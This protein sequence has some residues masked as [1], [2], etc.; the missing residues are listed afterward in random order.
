MALGEQPEAPRARARRRS[1]VGAEL[2]PKRA[3]YD[4]AQLD[5]RTG[6]LTPSWMRASVP[7]EQE[8]LDPVSTPNHELNDADV[9]ARGLALEPPV[10]L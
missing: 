6:A 1:G 3:S 2:W 5:T 7:S 9:L 10:N 4:C 8:M